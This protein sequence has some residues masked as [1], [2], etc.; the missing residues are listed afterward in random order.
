MNLRYP[1]LILVSLFLPLFKLM[2]SIG[3]FPKLYGR[4]PS[5]VQILPEV[6]SLHLFM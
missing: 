6:T 2:E 4:E 1:M 3:L 5:F